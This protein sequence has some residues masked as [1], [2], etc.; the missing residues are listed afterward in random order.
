MITVK[1]QYLNVTDRW[2]DGRTTFHG[3]TALCI[4]SRGKTTGS[5]VNATSSRQRMTATHVKM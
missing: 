4:A 3:N 1:S 2:T 5:Y